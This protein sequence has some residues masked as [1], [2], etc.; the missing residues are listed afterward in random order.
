MEGRKEGRKEKGK[1]VESN[2]EGGRLYNAPEK[3]WK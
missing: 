3:C 1:G 2:Y